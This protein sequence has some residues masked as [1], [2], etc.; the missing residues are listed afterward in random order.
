MTA[1]C[2]YPQLLNAVRWASATLIFTRRVFPRPPT[3]LVW[4]FQCGSRPCWPASSASLWRSSCKSTLSFVQSNLMMFNIRLPDALFSLPQLIRAVLHKPRGVPERC[5]GRPRDTW[6]ALC[7]RRRLGS[8]VWGNTLILTNL[9]VRFYEMPGFLSAG[10]EWWRKALFFLVLLPAAVE[11]WVILSHLA[12]STRQYGRIN[13]AVNGIR[14]WWVFND[15]LELCRY[16]SRLLWIW[17]DDDK[18]FWKEDFGII[19]D[20]D[21]ERSNIDGDHSFCLSSLF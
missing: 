2:D 5:P 13:A 4:F 17:D 9:R 14:V 18:R 11:K 7:V 21:G 20:N 1:K 10:L 3:G 8:G 16:F 15:R 19:W 12:K 6:T